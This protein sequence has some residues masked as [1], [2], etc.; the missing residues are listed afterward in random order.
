MEFDGGGVSE[1]V[2]DAEHEVGGDVDGVAVHDGGDAGAGGGCEEGDLSVGEFFV[3][4]D[5]DDF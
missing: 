2:E 4:D 1:G 5:I 3:G